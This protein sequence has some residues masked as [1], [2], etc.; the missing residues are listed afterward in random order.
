MKKALTVLGLFAI[1][2]STQAECESPM[3]NNNF[4]IALKKVQSHDF[5]EAKKEAISKLFASCLTS[6]QVKSLLKQLSFEEDKLELAKVA[7]KN[8]SDPE[9]FAVI[10]SVFD[11]DDSK[12]EIDNLLK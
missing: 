7:F 12:K 5:D 1:T 6:E 2:L 4:Q 9:N 3:D 11:F 8:V 10:K